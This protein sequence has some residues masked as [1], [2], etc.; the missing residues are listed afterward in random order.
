MPLKKRTF[1]A[2][3]AMLVCAGSSLAA[4]PMI[5]DDARTVDAKA[6]Q[7]ESWLRFNRDSKEF[8]ALPAC[9][10]SGNLELTLGGAIE[11]SN[12]GE[13]T[14]DVV[15]QGKTLFRPLTTDGYGIGLVFG[16]VRHPAIH[17][18]SNALADYYA[19]LP[20]SFSFAGDRFFLHTNLGLIRQQENRKTRGTWGLGSETQLD[21]SNWL[22]AETFGQSNGKSYFQVGIRHWVI[23]DRVQIDTTWGDRIQHPGSERWFSVGLRLL[24]PAFLP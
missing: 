11:R 16:S 17:T 3:A 6:C 21:E 12:E 23:P 1:P 13:R 10:F 7:V 19:Y 14:T 2:L 22:I 8:W 9:N 4:R 15:I 5:T 18:E 24:S 20:A